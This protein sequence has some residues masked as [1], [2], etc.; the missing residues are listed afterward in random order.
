MANYKKGDYVLITELKHGITNHD[1]FIKNTIRK[2]RRVDGVRNGLQTYDVYDSIFVLY[3]DEIKPVVHK[4]NRNDFVRVVDVSKVGNHRGFKVGDIVEIKDLDG[5]LD[6]V[7]TYSIYDN[8][9][10]LREDEIEPVNDKTLTVTFEVPLFNKKEAHRIAHKMVEKAF[11]DAEAEAAKTAP[12]KHEDWTP[13]EIRTAQD[14]IAKLVHY[15]TVNGG[16]ISW[17]KDNRGNIWCRHRRDL[18]EPFNK[19]NKGM[20]KKMPEDTYNEWIGK[21]VSLCHA[22]RYPLPTFIRFKNVKQ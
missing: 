22:M 15:V 7:V 8:I 13:E 6:G 14:S 18:Y 5:V 1:N 16:D 12:K 21:Y 3:E 17:A 10:V 20:A 19:A 9:Y 11:N 4:Y 2:I